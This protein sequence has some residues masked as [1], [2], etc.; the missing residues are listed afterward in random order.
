MSCKSA[1]SFPTLPLGSNGRESNFLAP[2]RAVDQSPARDRVASRCPRF[3]NTAGGC[4]TRRRQERASSSRTPLLRLWSAIQFHTLS[5]LLR[6][7]L[8]ETPS[9]SDQ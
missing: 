5:G 1:K 4:A 8:A 2:C 9:C 7:V 3:P 6:Q